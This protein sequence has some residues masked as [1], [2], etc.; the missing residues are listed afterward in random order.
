ML[1]ASDFDARL[2]AHAQKKGAGR[3]GPLIGAV[4]GDFAE[5]RTVPH[6][7]P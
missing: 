5:T 2:L 3:P 1:A 6:P 4:S 7:P